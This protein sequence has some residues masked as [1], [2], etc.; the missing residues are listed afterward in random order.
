MKTK[1]FKTLQ[2]SQP[3]MEIY[4]LLQKTN[5]VVDDS[6]AV[7][8]DTQ[9]SITHNIRNWKDINFVVLN[10]AIQLLGSHWEDKE[11]SWFLGPFK[12]EQK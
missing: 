7:V 10:R 6:S 2:N 3:E 4:W 8:N 9:L 5:A 1:I 11:G 12:T